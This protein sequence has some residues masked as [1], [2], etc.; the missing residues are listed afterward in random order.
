MKQSEELDEQL[1]PILVGLVAR[2]KFVGEGA[3]N[4]DLGTPV[5][6]AHQAIRQLINDEINTYIKPYLD[7]CEEVNGLPFCKNCGL[8]KREK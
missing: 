5:Q 8:T 3:P 6:E 1:M 7:Y 2:G 4:K